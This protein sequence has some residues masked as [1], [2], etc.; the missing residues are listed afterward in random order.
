MR[1]QWWSR[2]GWE[3]RWQVLA[4]DAVRKVWTSQYEVGANEHTQELTGLEGVGSDDDDD[5]DLFGA[6]EAM[7]G[8]EL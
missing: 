7:K 6:P 5:E 8:S 3:P 4:K 1:F 2:K